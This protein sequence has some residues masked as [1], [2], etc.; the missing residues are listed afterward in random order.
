MIVAI[1]PKETAVDTIK[2]ISVL[3]ILGSFQF[4]SKDRVQL[5]MIFSN[6]CG[7]VIIP[8]GTLGSTMVCGSNH[9]LSLL[10]LTMFFNLG[11]YVFNTSLSMISY[12]RPTKRRLDS[13][14]P[15]SASV[16]HVESP[17]VYTYEYYRINYL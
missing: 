13:T 3:F 12:N 6:V 17:A 15:C 4:T 16:F 14:N 8:A 11:N 1:P 9:Q 2:R 7:V 5:N 10:R